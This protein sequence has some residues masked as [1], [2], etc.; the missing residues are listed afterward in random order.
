M[1]KNRSLHLQCS[2]GNPN[3]KAH[4]VPSLY[5]S[6]RTSLIIL[7]DL[8]AAAVTASKKP[9]KEHALP[10]LSKITCVVL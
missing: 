5:L 10:N 7:I 2:G 4:H 1:A 3:P 8:T 9:I 6:L